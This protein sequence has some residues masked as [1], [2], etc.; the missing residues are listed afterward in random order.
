MLLMW[1]G[2]ASGVGPTGGLRDEVW[3]LGDIIYPLFAYFI[4]RANGL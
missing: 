3:A 2:P 4:S 1:H